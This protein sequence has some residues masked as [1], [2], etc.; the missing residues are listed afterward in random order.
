[1]G[2]AP[3][4]PAFWS[5]AVASQLAPRAA[6][7]E[8]PITKPKNRRPAIPMVAGEPT[9]SSRAMTSSGLLGSSGSGS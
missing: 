4:S 9:S 6:G 1:M 5:Q 3:K 7:S 8:P 2:V